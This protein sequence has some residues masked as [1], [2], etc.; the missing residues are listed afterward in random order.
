[1]AFSI[2]H[3]TFSIFDLI[4]AA[5]ISAAVHYY[6]RVIAFPLLS[7]LLGLTVIALTMTHPKNIVRLKQALAH[8][9]IVIGRAEA[10]SE[11]QLMRAQSAVDEAR[12]DQFKER[13]RREAEYLVELQKYISQEEQ[14][15]AMVSSISN[16]DLR[17]ALARELGIEAPEFPGEL[18]ATSR[19]TGRLSGK[20]HRR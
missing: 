1:M 19:E 6:S 13:S 16:R 9:R 15:R 2:V 17:E 5:D 10:A 7:G 20:D 14:K 11:L 12:L 3:G 18:D 8:M 4:G